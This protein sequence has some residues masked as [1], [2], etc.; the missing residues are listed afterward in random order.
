MPRWEPR[1]A[2]RD[3][4]D[5]A[6]EFLRSGDDKIHSK[7]I[8]TGE[9]SRHVHMFH[10]SFIP[11]VCT[12]TLKTSASRGKG[13]SRIELELSNNSMQ[14]HV[15][16]FTTGTYKMAHRH[17]PGSHVVTLNGLGY[18]LFW[19]G[20]NRYSEA[21]ERKRL[22]WVRWKPLCAPDGWFH[23]HFNTGR[24]S[25]RYI[26]PSWGGDAEVHGGTRRTRIH[27]SAGFSRREEGRQHD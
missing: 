21:P 24:D 4:F 23:Q 20:S 14:T 11:D 3:R 27:T 12:I 5:E 1:Y 22:D 8:Q 2:F 16:E 6:S 10:G 18:T 19:K 9:R 25:A 15:S 13:N 17:G 26:A 7:I